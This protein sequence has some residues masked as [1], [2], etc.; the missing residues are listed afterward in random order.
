MN[1]NLNRND[2]PLTFTVENSISINDL[3]KTVLDVQDIL[4]TKKYAK[5]L[6]EFISECSTPTTIGVQ[7]DWGIGK[8]SMM[9]MIRAHLDQVSNVK[10]S[11]KNYGVVWFNTWQYSLFGQDEYLGLSAIKGLLETMKDSLLNEKER[12]EIESNEDSEKWKHWKS[13]KNIVSSLNVSVMGISVNA[14]EALGGQDAEVGKDSPIFEDISKAMSLFKQQFEM[15]VQQ[16]KELKRFD[17]I[18]FFIDDLDRVKPLKALE[19]LESLK[20]FLD[21][22]NGVFV[23][24]VDYEVVQMGMKEKFGVDLQKQSGKSFFDKI[25]QLPF[26]MPASSYNIENYI[27]DLLKDAKLANNKNWDIKNTDLLAAEV[28]KEVTLLTIG[29]NPRSIKRVINYLSLITKLNR[30]ESDNKAGSIDQKDLPL[31]YCIVCM[32]IAWPEIFDH[33]IEQPTADRIKHIEDWDYLS[34]IPFI[35]KLYDRTPNIDQLKS[36]ISSYFDLLFSILD[37][38]DE[39]GNGAGDGQL[40]NKELAPLHEVLH[41]CNYTK[42]ATFSDPLDLVI[43]IVGEKGN[44]NIVKENIDF[45]DKIFRQS[46]WNS[47]NV[48]LNVTGKRYSTIVINRKQ[49]GSLV[50]LKGDILIFRLAIDR[51]VLFEEVKK[52]FQ[53]LSEKLFEEV[54]P[55]TSGFGQTRL[56]IGELRKL[57]SKTQIEILNKLY[58]IVKIYKDKF[59]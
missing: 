39:K 56:N 35:Q 9:N 15:L 3:E 16:I 42:F 6:Y 44:T 30:R 26:M 25:I 28:I 41:S 33:F 47:N 58:S 29:S 48:S 14:K 50:S 54:P 49:I 53:E 8:T 2:S 27:M 51:N 4:E 12:K 31:L 24:A 11:K 38:G 19:L 20:N 52:K 18:V 5:A 32:Q 22:E 7:G 1:K 10:G 45:L 23:L 55:S 17:R 59:Q 43:K 36:K 46:T 13:V 40:T 34:N 57:D 21:V 37:V